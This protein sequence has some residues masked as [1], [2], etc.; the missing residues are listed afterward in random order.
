[1]DSLPV[2][3]VDLAREPRAALEAML[4]AGKE[5]RACVR[6]LARTGD[7]LV[8]ELLK[9]QGEFT[10]WT[11]YP[12]GDVHDP[13]THSEYYYHAH[14]DSLIEAA[15]ASSSGRRE[16]GHFHCFLRASGMPAGTRPA[17]VAGLARSEIAGEAIAHLV[18]IAM[19]GFGAPIRLFTVNRWVTGET[20]YAGADVTAMLERFAIARAAPSW[21]VNRWL[22][23]MLRL[24]RPEIAAL[25]EA[26]DAAVAAYAASHPETDALEDRALEVT[27]SLDIDVERQIAAVRAALAR[28]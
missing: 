17:K 5:A 14:G 7:N 12:A 4:A 20:W 15:C 22:G 9:G 3:R 21:P 13:S 18:A 1:M 23:A 6:E 27:S 25:I 28:R 8:G 19:D 2:V 16:H 11:H 24:F 10:A 26:R